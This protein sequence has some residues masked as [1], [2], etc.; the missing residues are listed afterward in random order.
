VL[1]KLNQSK[2]VLLKLIFIII[3]AEECFPSTSS[4]LWKL[5]RLYY[6]DYYWQRD[7]DSTH[8][9]THTHTL[10]KITMNPMKMRNTTAMPWSTAIIIICVRSRKKMKCKS[11]EVIT[12]L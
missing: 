4:T 10:G 1:L 11:L 8:T 5:Q 6:Q 2:E 3:K 12:C 9:H 7:S